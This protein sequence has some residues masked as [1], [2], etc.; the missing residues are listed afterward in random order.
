MSSSW[1]KLRLYFRTKERKLIGMEIEINYVPSVGLL[2]YEP[3]YGTI[4]SVVYEKNGFTALLNT[5]IE[6]TNPDEQLE[7]L[8]NSGWKEYEL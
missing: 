3:I 1:K 4:G 6:S 5:V 7:Y 8:K 2:I